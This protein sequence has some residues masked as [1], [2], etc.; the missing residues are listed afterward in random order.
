I[1]LQHPEHR[2]RG[3]RRRGGLPVTDR[4]TEPGGIMKLLNVI[5]AVLN[6][7]HL[8]AELWEW[9]EKHLPVFGAFT[10]FLG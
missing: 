3:K 1:G 8:A 7:L 6:C 5:E 9:L 2:I 4:P 10:L